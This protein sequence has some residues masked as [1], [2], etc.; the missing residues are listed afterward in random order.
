MK[1]KYFFPLILIS[2]LAFSQTGKVGIGTTTPE[3]TLD[4]AG[5]LKVSN[6]EDSSNKNT[7][8]KILVANSNGNVD[9]ILKKDLLPTDFTPN[10]EVHN[11]IYNMP[12]GEG[13]P[14]KIV[15]CGKFKFRFNSGSTS[16][17]QFALNEAPPADTNVYM[18]MEQ[19]W[20]GNGF[21]FFQGTAN[22]NT[23]PFTFTP[24][25]YGTFQNFAEANVVNSE[26]NI[27]HFQYPGDLSF[28][29]LII[30]RVQQSSSSYD[31][32]ATCEKF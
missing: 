22:N 29:R 3:R 20:S 12:V 9:Y 15:K 8:D 16:N 21:Q 23:N 6:L 19:N 4:I 1:K 10:K 24:T 11:A 17:I 30:Y 28:Y 26:Q 25:N 2:G 32:V 31:F 7:Y 5:N 13:N 27:M 18:S 14:A